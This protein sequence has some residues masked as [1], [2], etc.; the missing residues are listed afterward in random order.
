MKKILFFA[1]VVLCCARF[2]ATADIISG[3]VTDS[4]TGKPLAHA[5][6]YTDSTHK[7]Y[8]DSLGNFSFNTDG[9]VGIMGPNAQSAKHV[10]WEPNSGS[11]YVTGNSGA[12]GV[13]IRNVQGAVVGKF[14]SGNLSADS[15]ISLASLPRGIY[16]ASVT[17]GGRTA[18]VKI[19]NV[20]GPAMANIQASSRLNAPALAKLSAVKATT[21]L[22]FHKL[23]HYDVSRTVTGPQ[24][25]LAIKLQENFTDSRYDYL[26]AGD[27]H[28]HP[29]EL[30]ACPHYKKR[31]HA[32]CAHGLGKDMRIRYVDHEA[33]MGR[34]DERWRQSLV[35]R[36]AA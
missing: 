20:C 6:V 31:D 35:G 12:I 15:R 19:M 36:V 3:V 29:H 23:A 8:T 9:S 34:F 16:M 1:G 27:E 26:W 2:T 18:V 25:G 4:A 32:L 33:F 17:V 14:S 5:R 30:S 22:N 11:F 21:V 24:T 13:Q 28:L 7:V 10:S